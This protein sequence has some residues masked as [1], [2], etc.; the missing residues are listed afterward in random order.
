MTPAERYAA[1][2]D[3]AIAQRTRLRGELPAGDRWTG[4]RAQMFRADPRRPLTADL[5]LVAEYL[6]PDDTFV[7]V[8]GGAGRICL[9]MA[10]RCREVIDV[11]PS[12][13]MQAEF[14]AACGE[15]GITNARY[16]RRDWLDPALDVQSVQGDVTLAANVTYFMRDIVPFLQ[17]LEAAARR[18][19]M[20][21]IGS[22]P[23]PSQNALLFRLVWD[24]EEEDAAGQ[25]ELLP[26]LWAMGRVPE[27]RVLSRPMA[28][29][30][31][32]PQTRDEALAFA[33]RAV[34]HEQW[35]AP[36][37]GEPEA[38]ARR[39]IEAHFD[40]LFANQDDGFHPL[41]RRDS[42]LVLITWPV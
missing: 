24:E 12:A 8:G 5:A 30:G 17:K 19:A 35:A 6:Q 33:L 1:R 34:G 26:V 23:P 18:R 10:L 29:L 9:P 31:G 7:D 25:A 13:G 20:V 11:D 41:W 16:I 14:D 36:P 28:V 37:R 27:V 2:V 32:L 38:H 4:P 21:L 3:A 42:Y 22:V 15:A 39:V 40:T